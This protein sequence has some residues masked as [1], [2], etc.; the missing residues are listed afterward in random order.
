[1]KYL[2]VSEHADGSVVRQTPADVSLFNDEK[3]AF[4]DVASNPSPCVKFTLVSPESYVAIEL[5][6]G[7]F[8]VNGLRFAAHAPEVGPIDNVEL[9]Y[10]R[11][12]SHPVRFGVSD[13][14]LIAMPQPEEPIV[15]RIGFAGT[16]AD[17]SVFERVLEVA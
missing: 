2:F 17:G 1:M 10:F 8:D 3:S 16:L 4:Y 12:R 6:T 7:V 9:R 15:F 13:E 5:T 11:R 14:G